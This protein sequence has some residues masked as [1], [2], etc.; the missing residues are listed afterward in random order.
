M[1]FIILM[2]GT[3]E[4]YHRKICSSE[5]HQGSKLLLALCFAVLC[6]DII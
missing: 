4:L 1:R 2:K 3:P 5:C 6:V